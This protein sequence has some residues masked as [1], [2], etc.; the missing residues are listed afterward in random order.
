MTKKRVLIVDDEKELL[1]T[2]KIRLTS[3]GYDVLTADN[4][5]EAIS[6]FKKKAVDVVILDIMMPEMDG[7]EI[8]KC[9]RRFNKK[10]PVIILTAYSDEERFDKF[11]KLGMAGFIQKGTAFENAL[12]LVQVVLKGQKMR[13]S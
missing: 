6:L 11:Y 1:M 5:K 9:I 10:I 3:W 2:M 8:L 12:E 13:N 4:G 7:I